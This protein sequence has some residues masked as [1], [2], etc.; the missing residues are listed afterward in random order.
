MITIDGS[1]KTMNFIVLPCNIKSPQ[2]M[3]Y[4]AIFVPKTYQIS[5]QILNN[6]ILLQKFTIFP[7]IHQF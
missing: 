4:N 5:N 3:E 1:R 7:E 2:S 6:L